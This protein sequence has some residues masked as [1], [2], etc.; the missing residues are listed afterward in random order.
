[1]GAY[2][3]FSPTTTPA[4]CLA[5]YGSGAWA[6]LVNSA[7]RVSG[8][9]SG[10]DASGFNPIVP[11]RLRLSMAADVIEGS[12]DGVQLFSVVDDKYAAGNAAVGSGWH[13]IEVMDFAVE[14]P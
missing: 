5:L 7:P 3:G 14:A 1:M 12:V 4:Y 9:L 10:T 2:D 8:N 13:G 6:L 11:H